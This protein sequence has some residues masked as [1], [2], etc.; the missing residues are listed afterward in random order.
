MAVS[1][2]MRLAALELNAAIDVDEAA[3]LAAARTLITGHAP[4]ASRQ[5]GTN[6]H[7]DKS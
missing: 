3:D 7:S 2:G 1:S 4:V 5:S 6:I